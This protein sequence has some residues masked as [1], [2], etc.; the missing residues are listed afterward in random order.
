MMSETIA[1]LVVVLGSPNDSSGRL[2]PMGLGR[3]ELGRQTYLSLRQAD[4]DWRLLLTGGFNDHFNTTDKP[5]AFYA[6]ALLLEAGVPA[7][8]IV[9]FAVS[10]NTVDDALAARP[11]VEKHGVSRLVVVS[12]DFHLDRVTFV[13]TEVFP[14]RALRFLGAPHLASCT[15]EERDQLLA[16]ER[17]ELESLRTRRTSIVGGALSLDAWKTS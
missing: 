11:I 2:T 6:R 12:S 15:P 5:H 16:H 13:F 10:R 9:E 17:R 4:G 7:D 8:H 14:D 1:G 3:V